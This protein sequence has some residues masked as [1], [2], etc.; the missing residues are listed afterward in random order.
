MSNLGLTLGHCFSPKT[1]RTTAEQEVLAIIAP[2]GKL[3]WFLSNSWFFFKL[4]HYTALVLLAQELERNSGG[5]GTFKII[6]KRAFLLLN[7]ILLEANRAFSTTFHLNVLFMNLNQRWATVFL[8]RGP[9]WKQIRSMR[10]SIFTK[11]TN[12]WETNVF[13]LFFCLRHPFL[14]VKFFDASLWLEQKT[15]LG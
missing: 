6:I 1:R 12:F 5:P 10:A 13:Q 4:M 3:G 15:K 11:R 14:K 7:M 8:A 9:N 2:L